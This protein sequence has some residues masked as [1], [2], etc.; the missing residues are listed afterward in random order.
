MMGLGSD[1]P[2]PR[3]KGRSGTRWFRSRCIPRSRA[4]RH[5]FSRS[6]VRP[7]FLRQVAGQNHLVDAVSLCEPPGQTKGIVDVGARDPEAG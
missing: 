1:F 4:S 2:P 3:F 6:D 5:S 7:R